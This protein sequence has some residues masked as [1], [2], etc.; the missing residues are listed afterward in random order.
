[1]THTYYSMA[2]MLHNLFKE[3]DSI[4]EKIPVYYTSL[5]GNPTLEFNPLKIIFPYM[6]S[7]LPVVVN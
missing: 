2:L 1:M 5:R 7:S 3:C 4:S 6:K